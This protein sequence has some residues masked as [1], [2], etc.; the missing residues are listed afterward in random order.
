[1]VVRERDYQGLCDAKNP[2]SLVQ[3]VFAPNISGA[4]SADAWAQ[5]CRGLVPF[6]KQLLMASNSNRL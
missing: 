3:K 4:R 1:M 5:A 6:P 2:P